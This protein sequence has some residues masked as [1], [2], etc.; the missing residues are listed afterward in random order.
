MKVS[1]SLIALAIVFLLAAYLLPVGHGGD[2]G[3]RVDDQRELEIAL[4]NIA[5]RLNAN[6]PVMV[7]DETRLD[8]AEVGDNRFKYNYTLVNYLS[9]DPEAEA[10]TAELL[11]AVKWSACAEESMRVF[12]E[13]SV[14][15]VYHYYDTD[16]ELIKSITIMPADCSC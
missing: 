11:P 7:D 1:G 8:S 4:K 2:S 3:L 13:N 14:S 12:F 6:L 15:A 10:I 16:G 9:V 5:D